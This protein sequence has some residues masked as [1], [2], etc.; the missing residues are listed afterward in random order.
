MKKAK[1]KG[2]MYARKERWGRKQWWQW[3][4]E[5]WYGDTLLWRDDCRNPHRLIP[6]LT[7]TL[8]AFRVVIDLG[9]TKLQRW[10]DIV[11]KSRWA[12]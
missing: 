7:E 6:E 9:Q 4:A 5:V 8:A 3:Y 12:V 1:L 11:A 2:R 10:E